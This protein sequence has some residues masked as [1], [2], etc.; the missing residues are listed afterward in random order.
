MNIWYYRDDS[1]GDGGEPE[2]VT[3]QEALDRI[4]DYIQD[5]PQP[6][7]PVLTVRDRPRLMDGRYPDHE[8]KIDANRHAGI[9]AIL[10]SGPADFAP[11]ADV[12]GEGGDSWMSLAPT[13]HPRTSAPALYMD[14]ATRT[15]FPDNAVV[16]LELWRAALHELLETGKRP[17]C[18]QWQETDVF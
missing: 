15:K 1:C 3:T 13:V 4:L 8:V 2:V 9:G 17:T 12:S 14:K 10:C 16:P 7:P 6:H 11:D 5:H 18:V